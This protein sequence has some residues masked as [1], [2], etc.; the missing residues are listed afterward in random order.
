MTRPGPPLVTRGIERVVRL[1]ARSSPIRTGVT[2]ARSVSSA[3]GKTNADG[4]GARAAAAT[5]RTSSPATGGGVRRGSERT[6]RSRSRISSGAGGAAPR[7]SAIGS[8]RRIGL[9]D[10]GAKAEAV[11]P[12]GTFAARC[13]VSWAGGGAGASW[14]TSRES[15]KPL[16]ASPVD[17]MNA[18]RSA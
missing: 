4:A 16:V 13:G 15:A 10:V 9:L 1:S 5:G 17:G 12:G 6:V 14:A 18:S 3:V 7:G 2:A 11:T 8:L